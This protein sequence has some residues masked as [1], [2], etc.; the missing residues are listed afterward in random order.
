MT[1]L[2]TSPDN[3]PYPE[4]G[5]KIADTSSSENLINLLQQQAVL[6]QVALSAINGSAIK[7]RGNA[8]GLNLNTMFLP[9][10]HFGAWNVTSG[11]GATPLPDGFAGSGSIWVIGGS[12]YTV[13]QYLSGR[14]QNTVWQRTCLN[15]TATPAVWSEWKS[16]RG[17]QSPADGRNLDEM[18]NLVDFGVHSISY[19]GGALGMPAGFFGQGD[20]YVSGSSRFRAIQEI[21]SR[22][23]NAAWRRYCINASATPAVWSEWVVTVE[24]QVSNA[25]HVTVGDSLGNLLGS[26]VGTNMPGISVSNRGYNG[27]TTDGILLR[28]GAKRTR[29]TVSGGV[30]PASGSVAISTDQVLALPDFATVYSG[31]LNGVNGNIGWDGAGSYVFNRA[32]A[33]SD[34]TASGKVL[35]E[36][37]WTAQIQFMTLIDTMGRNDISLSSVGVDDDV[38]THIKANYVELFNWAKAERKQVLF[39]GTLNRTTEPEGHANYALVA[40]LA[41]WLKDTFPGNYLDWRK[42]IVHQAIYDLGIT[43]TAEDL[44]NMANDCPPPSV[45]TDATHPIPEA[46]SKTWEK[47]IRPWELAKGWI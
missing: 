3:I 12:Q 45:M 17:A 19:N 8:D 2:F 21:V 38:I 16:D 43:P 18:F 10:Q 6:T 31:H 5:T 26:N 9:S 36:P 41:R 29:W 24:P 7:I 27:E 34:V 35:F 42:Y 1:Y 23:Q 44:A 14:D 4:P 39:L 40:E 15:S 37:R 46:A 20:L 13:T 25:T 28:I 11:G 33:G 22:E 30:I 32:E 47:L